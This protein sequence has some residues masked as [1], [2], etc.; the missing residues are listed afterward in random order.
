MTL[1]VLPSSPWPSLA[2]W[3][4]DPVFTD[5]QRRIIFRA[6]HDDGEQEDNGPNRSVYIDELIRW[7][8][9]NPAAPGGVYWCAIVVGRWFVDG[10]AKVPKGFPACDS[11]LPH[12]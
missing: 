5:I 10:G 2:R 7:A 9:L 3:L 11:W 12:A 8:G 1:I 6:K 4:A